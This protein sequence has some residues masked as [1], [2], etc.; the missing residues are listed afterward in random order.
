[1]KVDT[2]L[3]NSPKTTEYSAPRFSGT[4]RTNVGSG[5][6]VNA[7]SIAAAPVVTRDFPLWGLYK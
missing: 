2:F 3:S 7:V 6:G 4:F 1:M 5:S